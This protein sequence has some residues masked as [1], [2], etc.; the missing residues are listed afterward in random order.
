MVLLKNSINCY[1]IFEQF[2]TLEQT[3]FNLLTLGKSRFPQKK[4]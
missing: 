2:R 4:V 3:L 1:H